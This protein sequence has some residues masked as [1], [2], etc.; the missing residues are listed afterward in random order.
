MK[1]ARVN[2]DQEENKDTSG[3]NCLVFKI[4]NREKEVLKEK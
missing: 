4:Q 2:M 1:K 3:C